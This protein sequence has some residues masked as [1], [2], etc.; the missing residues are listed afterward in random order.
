MASFDIPYCM[1]FFVS[2]SN[3]IYCWNQF[4][5]TDRKCFGITSLILIRCCAKFHMHFALC[6]GF[7]SAA[8]ETQW[9]VIFLCVTPM[10]AVAYALALFVCPI[11]QYAA[12][13]RLYVLRIN[14]TGRSILKARERYVTCYGVLTKCI[15]KEIV[16]F[17]IFPTVFAL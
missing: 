6:V 8:I 15:D 1:V 12:L 3:T 14:N 10:T 11:V 16:F 7:L 2:Y 17:F 5:T 9:A 13:Y 4:C